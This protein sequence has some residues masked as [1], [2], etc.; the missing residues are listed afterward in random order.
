MEANPEPLPGLPIWI[1][2]VS[3]FG[4][5]ATSSYFLV[6]HHDRPILLADVPLTGIALGLLGFLAFVF[7]AL[8]R[9]DEAESIDAGAW[10]RIEAEGG[11]G[12]ETSLASALKEEEEQA[13]GKRANEQI[14]KSTAVLILAAIGGVLGAFLLDL[15]LVPGLLVV[16]LTPYLA[17][18]AYWGN[19]CVSERYFPAE[20]TGFREGIGFDK[21]GKKFLRFSAAL[22]GVLGG[23]AIEFSRKR[24][25]AA[26]VASEAAKLA[27]QE[28]E[29]AVE[30]RS[31]NGQ[32][33]VEEDPQGAH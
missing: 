19:V 27:M 1:G 4:T 18:S 23:G 6:E 5:I 3:S 7:L 26:R 22:Y 29:R 13:L 24:G 17:W 12:D 14:A 28:A 2:L 20:H 8:R 33:V 21:G 30:E 15:G 10:R 16:L 11:A 32:Q 25:R 31:G 9:H